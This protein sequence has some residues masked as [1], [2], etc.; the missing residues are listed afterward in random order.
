MLLMID[1]LEDIEETS[2]EIR[3]LTL[4]LMKLARREEK[5][6][7][8]IVSEFIKNAYLLQNV[9]ESENTVEMEEKKKIETPALKK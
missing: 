3:Y 1:D 7:E 6:F 2:S 4:E 8:D 5:K 9:I